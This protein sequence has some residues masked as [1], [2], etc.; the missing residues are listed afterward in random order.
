MA[1]FSGIFIFCSIW[2]SIC[3][4]INHQ[5]NNFNNRNFK[6]QKIFL[7]LSLGFIFTFSII[8]L[9]N[10]IFHLFGFSVSFNIF[11]LIIPFLIVFL[12]YSKINEFCS[13]L[14]FTIFKFQKFFKIPSINKNPFAFSLFF[15]II[16]QTLCIAIRL[17][18]PITHTDAI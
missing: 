12:N 16:L 8:G 18:L 11:L 2:I 15:I 9:S 1:I 6:N 10:I 5:I 7:L 17:L 13:E 4:D 3:S 14:F